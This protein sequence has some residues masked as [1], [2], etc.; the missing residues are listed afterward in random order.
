M[1]NALTGLFSGLSPRYYHY[2]SAAAFLEIVKNGEIWASDL[3]SMNDPREVK[4]GLPVVK[5]YLDSLSFAEGS[6]NQKFLEEVRAAF[7]NYKE[8]IKFLGASF[9]QRKDDLYSW[10][11]YSDGGKGFSIAIEEDYFPR[12]WWRSVIYEPQLFSKSIAQTFEE[13]MREYSG[14]DA[15][16]KEKMPVF[17]AIDLV[18]LTASYK[19]K[20]W[21]NERET[22]LLIPF[23]SMAG[24][25][26]TFEI[27]GDP[28]PFVQNGDVGFRAT[29]NNIRAFAGLDLVHADRGGGSR[30][31]IAE[32]I[33]GPNNRSDRG[34]VEILLNDYGFDN[35]TVSGSECEF[36]E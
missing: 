26:S 15:N 5:D 31:S 21:E 24:E 25:P 16:M 8:K 36:V 27:F 10:M 34:V 6:E 14:C 23:G 35:A 29:R 9:T 20:S 12:H 17:C 30:P 11:N 2:C 22:R 32:V 28:E 19:H 33:I 1:Q 3:E 7:D 4:N 18:S 13:H